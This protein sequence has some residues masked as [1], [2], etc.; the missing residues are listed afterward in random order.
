MWSRIIP[1]AEYYAEWNPIALEIFTPVEVVRREFASRKEKTPFLDE[2][3]QSL[4][5]P[6]QLCNSGLSAY[7]DETPEER[8]EP[9]H[10]R[11]WEADRKL[12]R[13]LFRT[14]MDV[15]G[16]HFISSN[17]PMD[18]VLEE[19]TDP[20][21]GTLDCAALFDLSEPDRI[22]ANESNEQFTLYPVA[23]GK[24]ARWGTVCGCDNFTLVGGDDEFVSTFVER[25]GG[26]KHIQKRYLRLVEIEMYYDQERAINLSKKIGWPIPEFEEDDTEWITI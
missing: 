15:D 9:E 22:E 20:K 16:N 23:F 18:Y 25:C 24:S 1:R 13:E 3:W 5:L 19:D 21:K 12:W 17:M 4:M 6:Y 26:L 14:I 10:W 7:M 8:E 11:F 2:N